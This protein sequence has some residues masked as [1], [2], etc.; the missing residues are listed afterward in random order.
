[1]Y[2]LRSVVAY[3]DFQKAFDTID[4]KIL[5]AKLKACGIGDRLIALFQNYLTGRKQRTKLFNAYSELKPVTIGVP[6]GSSIGPTM[7]IVYIIDLPTNLVHSKAIMYADDTV[8]YCSDDVNKALR[9]RFQSDLHRVQKWC[10]NDKLT[11]NVKK[12]QDYDLYE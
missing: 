2:T 7:F 3:L 11:L 6:Q 12:D 10:S 9:K 4:H 1:M 8:L 5:L